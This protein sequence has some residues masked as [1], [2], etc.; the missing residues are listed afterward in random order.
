MLH[1]FAHLERRDHLTRLIASAACTLFWFN[2]LVWLASR[3]L[4]AESECACDDRVIRA[5]V[6]PVEYAAH[7]LEVARD[8][9]EVRSAWAA[10]GMA[11]PFDLEFRVR[12]ILRGRIERPS[13]E[14]WVMALVIV[15]SLLVLLALA[16]LRTQLVPRF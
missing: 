4:R 5:G 12:H 11:R 2:P 14:R 15:A 10:A 3:R 8:S 7:L 16:P 1:E 13:S 9:R 6:P